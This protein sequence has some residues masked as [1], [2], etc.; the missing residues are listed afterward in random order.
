[1]EGMKCVRC[2]GI[3]KKAKLRFQGHEI[4]GWKCECGEEYFNPEEAER[5]LLLNKLKRESFTVT[6]GKNRNNLI[7]RIPVKIQR[8]LGLK[9]G[10]KIRLEVENSKSLRLLLP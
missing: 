6:L 10:E 7:I 4:S 2:G 3:A 8:A 1:M 9:P 5:I